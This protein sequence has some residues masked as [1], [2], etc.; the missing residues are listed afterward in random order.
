MSYELLEQY[1]E[2][3]TNVTDEGQEHTSTMVFTKVQFDFLN[4]EIVIAHFNPVNQ[5]AIIT[6]IENREITELR[7]LQ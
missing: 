2:V 4:Y 5:A 6:G 1:S 7:K 3:I